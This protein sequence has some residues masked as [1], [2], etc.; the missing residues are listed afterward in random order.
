M[1]G[2]HI[3]RTSHSSGS[4]NVL[5]LCQKKLCIRSPAVTRITGNEFAVICLNIL[6]VKNHDSGNMETGIPER[7]PPLI[8]LINTHK[9]SNVKPRA[10]LRGISRLYI[11]KLIPN[12]RISPSGFG[13]STLLTGNGVSCP[14]RILSGS[15]W[16]SSRRLSIS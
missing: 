8:G 1:I 6:A 10:A 16:Q 2:N 9:E 12:F 4:G 11:V 5:P 13:I 7:K 14:F 3:I 15:S